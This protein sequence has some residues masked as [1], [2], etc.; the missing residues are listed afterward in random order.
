[1]IWNDYSK[2]TNKFVQPYNCSKPSKWIMYLDANNLHSMIEHTVEVFDCVSPYEVKLDNYFDDGL[3]GYFLEVDF[4]YPDKL[5]NLHNGY[6]LVL[7][8]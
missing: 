8:Q 6:L 3:V 5:H 4:D 7:K 1:M 2:A